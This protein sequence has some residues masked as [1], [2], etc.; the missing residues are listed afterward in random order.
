MKPFPSL[1]RRYPEQIMDYTPGW[2]RRTLMIGDT[3]HDLLLA[4]I[5]ARDA[6]VWNYG[7]SPA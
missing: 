5:P 6:M 3:S 7:T 1:T 4:K 2:T